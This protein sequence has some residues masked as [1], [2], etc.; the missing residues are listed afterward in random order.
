MVILSDV[1]FIGSLIAGFYMALKYA[2]IAVWRLSMEQ[3]NQEKLSWYAMFY[4][5]GSTFAFL[6][7][8][9]VKEPAAIQFLP[10]FFVFSLI[11]GFLLRESAMNPV[12][13]RAILS[14]LR[15]QFQR[16]SQDRDKGMKD[17]HQQ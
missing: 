3:A 9:V 8:L 11:M 6:L 14:K 12:R 7:A 4:G 15:A 17:G 2:H 5:A 16:S 10:H 1:F 13:S